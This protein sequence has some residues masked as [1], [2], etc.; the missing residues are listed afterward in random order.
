VVGEPHLLTGDALLAYSSDVFGQGA[1]PLAMVSPA[2]VAQLQAVVRLAA[3]A[4]LALL[5]RG[6]GASY[7]A[8]YLAPEDGALLID[9]RRLDRVVE[10]H[11]EDAYVTVEAG[12]TW[13]RLAQAL[14][15][16]GLRTPFRGPFSGSVATVGGAMAQ[17]AI[18]HGTGGHGM[19]GVSV[20]SMDVVLADGT[21][22]RTG[23][24][25][26]HDSPFF[27]HCGPD[28]TGLFLGDCGALGIKARITL[29]LLRA[30][31][32]F[33]AASF[34]F[35]SF[36]ALHAGMQAAARLGVDDT[37]FALDAGMIRG[38]L[39][40]P[41]G[42]AA[43]LKT[44]RR[45]WSGAPSA[46]AG[47]W[48]LA[49]MAWAGERA[50]ASASHLAHYIVEGE[51]AA[52]VRRKLR[53]LQAAMR[54]H[55][56]P[57]TNTIPTVVRNQPF[58][59]MF[60]VLG[61][62]GERWVPVHGLM[63]HSRVAGFHAALQGLLQGHQAH[64]AQHGV[65]IGFLYECVGAG[66]FT[67]ELGLYWPDET[68]PYHRG[69]LGAEGLARVPA[70]AANPAL[71][72]WISALRQ[73]LIA[74]YQAHGAVHFQI[75]RAYPYARAMA[76]EGLATLRAIKQGLDPLGRLNPGALGL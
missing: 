71:R 19:S 53:L 10:I 35:D 42:L 48:Q 73:E 3:E 56:Q 75:G 40:R 68:T 17:H 70:H 13:D 21:L 59:R 33:A 63:P 55:G 51:D 24:A 36:E 14:A 20:L 32:D 46:L 64:M 29:P 41:R 23:S 72:D 37:H 52:I 1:T 47:L 45:V 76:P 44:A 54:P 66:A 43:T 4:G 38:Q 31:P 49:R 9:L 2:D 61:P 8:G 60:H 26:L 39:R 69:V 62:Q 34:G 12:V 25:L 57:L 22:L 30:R 67:I 6:G 50:M 18:S 27:R 65:W 15:P 16:H 28:L 5:P 74:L 7:T 58:E 11:A